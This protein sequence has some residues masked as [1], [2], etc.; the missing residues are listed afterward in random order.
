MCKMIIKVF[1]QEFI[2]LILCWIDNGF[3]LLVSNFD[4]GMVMLKGYVVVVSWMV[5][6]FVD[7]LM[8]VVIDL[9]FVQDVCEVICNS[10]VFLVLVQNLMF[11]DS[12]IIV[13]KVIG[14]LLCWFVCY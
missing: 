5:F 11:V 1:E 2:I 8:N 9:M 13:M 3:V 10:E 14:V 12:D 6:S 7:I 4:L